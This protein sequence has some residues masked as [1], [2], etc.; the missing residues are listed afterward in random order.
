MDPNLHAHL[1]KRMA[2]IGINSYKGAPLKREGCSDGGERNLPEP[3]SSPPRAGDGDFV[4]CRCGLCV[5]SERPLENKCCVSI[6]QVVAEGIDACITDHQHF[7]SLCLNPAVLE[8]VYRE[9]VDSRVTKHHDQH[10]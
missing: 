10:K 7:L 8:A 1:M 2:D 5:A 6:P 4:W 3:P 9:L